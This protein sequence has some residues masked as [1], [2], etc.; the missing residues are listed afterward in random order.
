MET[1]I[2]LKELDA[3][4]ASMMASLDELNVVMKP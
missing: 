4:S 3:A 1:L 2:L